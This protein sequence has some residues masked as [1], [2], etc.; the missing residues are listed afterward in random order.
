MSIQSIEIAAV[1]QTLPDFVLPSHTGQVVRIADYKGTK[2]LILFFMREFNCSSC[3]EYARRLSMLYPEIQKTS[4]E[5]LVVGLGGEL[6]AQS[7]AKRVNAPYPV[8]YDRDGAV[9]DLLRLDRVLFSVIQR[10]AAFVVDQNGVVRHTHH[11]TVPAQWRSLGA[12]ADVLTS[13]NV[14]EPLVLANAA[15]SGG[16]SFWQQTIQRLVSRTPEK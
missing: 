6:L 5:V 16:S 10:S 4:T 12:L 13:L 1:G 2:N 7:M 3:N 9:Y 11:I 8:L 14:Q 15:R